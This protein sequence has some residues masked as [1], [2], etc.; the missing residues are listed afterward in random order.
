MKGVRFEGDMVIISK[1]KD[2]LRPKVF[3]LCSHIHSCVMKPIFK[4]LSYLSRQKYTVYT[5]FGALF[6]KGTQ[7]KFMKGTSL[8]YLSSSKPY[9]SSLFSVKIFHPKSGLVQIKYKKQ[10]TKS[11]R[12][13][14]Q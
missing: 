6:M 7:Q 9:Y 8:L 14:P 12:K 11:L 10:C 2:L 4:P 13:K 3:L 1:I 5:N